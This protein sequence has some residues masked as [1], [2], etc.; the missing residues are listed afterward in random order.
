MVRDPH[1]GPVASGLALDDAGAGRRGR[2]EEKKPAEFAKGKG[3][4]ATAWFAFSVTAA[5]K[6]LRL[7]KL[8]VLLPLEP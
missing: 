2:K 7:T 1:G 3:T 6:K 5:D 4:L 8:L